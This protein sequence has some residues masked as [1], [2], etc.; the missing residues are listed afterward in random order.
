MSALPQVY[1]VN[2]QTRMYS[3]EIKAYR[4]DDVSHNVGSIRIRPPE[5]RDHPLSVSPDKLFLVT[6]DVMDVDF[7]EPEV[8]VVLDVLQMLVYV[9]AHQR[10]GS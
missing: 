7:V 6:P 2:N 10:P 3:F 4:F 5:F 8:H 1:E 9:G